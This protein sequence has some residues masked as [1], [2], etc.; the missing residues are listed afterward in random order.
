MVQ[1]TEPQMELMMHQMEW[2]E[3]KNSVPQMDFDSGQRVLQMGSFELLVVRPRKVQVLLVDPQ[4]DWASVPRLK[5]VQRRLKVDRKLLA[6]LQT[7]LVSVLTLK[8]GRMLHHPQVALLTRMLALEFQTDSVSA[9]KL[10]VGQKPLL[11][12]SAARMLLMVLQTGSA[13]VPRLKT[14]RSSPLAVAQTF[15]AELALQKLVLQ[16]ADMVEQENS[17]PQHGKK[18][19]AVNPRW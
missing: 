11:L 13:F 8:A 18:R 10:T 19:P 12:P 7:D 3:Q 4:M 17:S 9:P 5:V 2:A 16:L 14:G 15:L 6:V 1:E